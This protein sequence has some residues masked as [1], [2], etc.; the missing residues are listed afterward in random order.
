MSFTITLFSSASFCPKLKYIGTPLRSAVA[1]WD[2]KLSLVN[3]CSTGIWALRK[4][5]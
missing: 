4:Y 1:N 5:R 2:V 3:D